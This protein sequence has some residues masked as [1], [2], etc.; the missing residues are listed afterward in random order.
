[1]PY[2]RVVAGAQTGD[3]GPRGS[4]G[5]LATKYVIC[6]L[7]PF[8]NITKK[9]LTDFLAKGPTWLNDFISHVRIKLLRFD[10]DTDTRLR[11]LHARIGNLNETARKEKQKLRRA[12]DELEEKIAKLRRT[13]AEKFDQIVDSIRQ[14]KGNLTASMSELVSVCSLQRVGSERDTI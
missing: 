6:D 11:E 3:Q 13:E 7:T 2:A 12:P 5:R 1:M 4:F 9:S 8:I 10:T 14:T